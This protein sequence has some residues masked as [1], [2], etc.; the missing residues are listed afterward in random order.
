MDLATKKH[1]LAHIMA[2]AVKEHFPDA[3]L[4][5][6]PATDDG[7]YYDFDFGDAVITENDL[8]KIEKSMKKILSQKQKFIHFHVSYD[9]AREILKVMNEEFKNILID[10]FESGNFKNE[11][12]LE[13]GT[14]GFSINTSKGKSSEYYAKIQ[15]FLKEKNFYDFTE[16][17]GDQVKNLKFIDMCA[18][19]HIDSTA[20][21]DP[22]SFALA[23]I[24]GAYWLGDAKN[25]Q[26]TRIY[27]YA[28][29]TAEEL[30]SH[31]K[32]LEE[33]KKRDH[34]IL[35]KKMKLFTISD[36]VGSGLPLIQPRGMIMRKAIEDYLWS[37]HADK[38]YDRI[39]T[40]HLAKEDLYITSGHA[41]HYL[42]DMF[43]VWGGTSQE[44]FY[45]KPMNCPHHMQLFADNQFSYRD[46][47][48]RYFEP[49]TVYRD[50]KTG[51]LS[52]LT[53]VRSITQDDG[54]LFCRVT[55]IKDEVSTIVGIIKEFYKTFGLLDGYW[56][57]LSVRDPE[58]LEKYLGDESVWQTAEKALE[59]AAKANDLNYKRMEGEAAFYGPK[60][61]FMF[62]DAIG[63]EWQLATIQCDFNLP[64]RFELSF[65]NEEGQEERPV[66]IHRAISGSLERFMGIMIE[67]FAG[68]FPLWIAPEQVRIVPVGE[69]FME[70]AEDVF[71]EMKK[72]GIRVKL[73]DSSDS[74]SKKIRNAETA[75]V[76]YILVVGE[77]EKNSGTLAV[78][79]YKTKE[80]TNE[81]IA[82]FVSRIQQEINEKTL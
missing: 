22:N 25:Q 15:E 77:Q 78:R 71:V 62:K 18:G 52:G 4:G 20:D 56:V 61:D 38:G 81:N 72:H 64:N 53:R 32:M 48:I 80:Q 76:N 12:K 34:R 14:I 65:K 35:G 29:E 45:V 37:L 8:K 55:Q 33:A 44:K 21:I 39:W 63:R 24:A 6:G 31:L 50:E 13:S 54:H 10:R 47:P 19:P 7:F 70:Y 30:D 49:A 26:L 41:G 11:E 67:H 40:P 28:F 42:E 60:L 9:E 46:M 43:S 36:L 82:D 23:R 58:N 75:H 27:A 3:K 59:D 17:D 73:D 57:S 74:L 66:V 68:V 16:L 5:I 1:S 69:A 51:Q 79:N 2:Q